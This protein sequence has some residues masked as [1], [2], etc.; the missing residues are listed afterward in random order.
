MAYMQQYGS[1]AI[2]QEK[3]PV[4]SLNEQELNAATLKGTQVDERSG[5]ITHNGTTIG[6]MI[7]GKAYEFV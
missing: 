2:P 4:F 1:F 7:D 6:V 3:A 5:T